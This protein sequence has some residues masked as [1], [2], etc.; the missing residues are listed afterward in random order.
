MF[1]SLMT[2]V[3]DKRV[4]EAPSH[5]ATLYRNNREDAEAGLGNILMVLNPGTPLSDRI[6]EDLKKITLQAGELALEIGV[7]RA[8]VGLAVAEYGEVVPI[9][10]EFHDCLNAD[11]A[12]GNIVEVR[13]LVSPGL[14]KTGN[15]RGDMTARRV[16][17]PAEIF[18]G[19]AAG[20]GARS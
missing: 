10:A 5:L 14:F 3:S 17:V 15:G 13:L 7:Q 16:L 4:H 6:K 2:V 1:M 18:Q 20:A 11:V 9:G 8:T 12:K 19:P